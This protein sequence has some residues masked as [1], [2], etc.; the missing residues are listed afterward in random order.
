M[1]GDQPQIG[2][3][4]LVERN[5]EGLSKAAPD[6]EYVTLWVERVSWTVVIVTTGSRNRLYLIQYSR[7]VLAKLCCLFDKVGVGSA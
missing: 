7:I 1:D 4:R 2:N 6:T 5:D 3:V